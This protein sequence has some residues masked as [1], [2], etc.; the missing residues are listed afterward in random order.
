M[1]NISQN[2]VVIHSR[3]F[4]FRFPAP[5]DPMYEELC[6]SLCKF[7]YIFACITIIELSYSRSWWIFCVFSPSAFALWCSFNI[8][9]C[10]KTC[11]V[12]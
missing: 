3:D 2:A 1:V 11:I 6:I 12:H 7:A 8:Q 10:A 5:G 9:N 4:C